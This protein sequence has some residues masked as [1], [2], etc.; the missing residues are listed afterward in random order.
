MLAAEALITAR[1]ADLPGLA[2]GVHGLAELSREAV[3]GK[4]LPAIFVGTQGYRVLDDRSPGAVRIASRWLVVLV[5][6]HVGDLAGGS[7]ARASASDLARAVM[8]R[9]YRWQPAPGLQPLEAKEAPA[10]Q[11]R[12]GLLLFP[13]A[14]DCAEIIHTEGV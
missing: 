6:R 11:Y 8:G 2:G 13:L 9:L 1:L 5:V 12:E 3:L 4:R 7:T 14:F 10:P